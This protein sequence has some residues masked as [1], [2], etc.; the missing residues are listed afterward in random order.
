MTDPFGDVA[1]DEGVGGITR[2]REQ[3][4]GRFD[5]KGLAVRATCRERSYGGGGIVRRSGTAVPSFSECAQLLHR[6]LT[7]GEEARDR[8][9]DRIGALMAEHPLRG[10]VEERDGSGRIE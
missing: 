1:D 8:A 5:G 2:R 9:A 6:L 7:V 3:R 4:Y 10:R